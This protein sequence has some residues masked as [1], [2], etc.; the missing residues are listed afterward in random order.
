ML[1]ET[2]LIAPPLPVFLPPPELCASAGATTKSAKEPI[3]AARHTTHTR[4]LAPET[5]NQNERSVL[6]GY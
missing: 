4:I 3:A 6:I 5:L 1:A 2:A